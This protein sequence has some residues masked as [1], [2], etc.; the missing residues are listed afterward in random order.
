MVTPMVTAHSYEAL[1]DYFFGIELNKIF[2]PP[3]LLNKKSDKFEG[4]LL[5]NEKDPVYDKISYMNIE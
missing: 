4:Y 1:L 2:V 5:Y 3:H